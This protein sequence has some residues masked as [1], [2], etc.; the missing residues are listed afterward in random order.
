MG[1]EKEHRSMEKY[2]AEGRL[3]VGAA[4]KPTDD[5]LE[6]S[7]AA[8]RKLLLVFSTLRGPNGCPWDR[9]QDHRSIRFD[10]VEEA[11]ELVEAVERGD[12]EALKQELGDLLL[13]VV[14]HTQLAR[15]RGAFTFDRV[16]EG[17]TEKLI[18]RHPHVFGSAQVRDEEGLLRQW[19]RLKRQE[20][21]AQGQAVAS[22]FDGIPRSLPSLM[23]AEQIVKRARRHGLLDSA[24]P[25]GQN[26]GGEEIKQAAA[27]QMW[28]IVVRCVECGLSPEELFREFL[29]RLEKELRQRERS[30]SS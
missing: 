27:K 12:D 25:S 14:F 6:R 19:D 23:R 7:A 21:Q 17:L 3:E 16:V 15:E 9:Q 13:Q 20:R 29:D 22:V 5:E 24:S 1:E 28:D 2:E 26:T 4:L 18:H 10:A 30:G 8:L 11:Y